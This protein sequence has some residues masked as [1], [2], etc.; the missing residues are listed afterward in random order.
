[1]H[2]RMQS[3]RV[4]DM[5]CRGGGIDRGLFSWEIDAEVMMNDEGEDDARVYRGGD[6]SVWGV[7]G[8][9]IILM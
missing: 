6:R 3:R 2:Y 7:Y 4:N 9:G 8:G 1:M 5:D